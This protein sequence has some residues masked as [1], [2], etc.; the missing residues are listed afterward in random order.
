MYRSS[1]SS[2][3][4]T[5]I[6]RTIFILSIYYTRIV[7]KQFIIHKM[8]NKLKELIVEDNYKLDNWLNSQ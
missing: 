3:S 6:V 1:V 8:I 7:P 5:A 2:E 4:V